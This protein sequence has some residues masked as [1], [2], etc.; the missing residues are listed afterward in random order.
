MK[1]I[2]K[3]V[4][5]ERAIEEWLAFQR[6][7]GGLPLTHKFPWGLSIADTIQ[8]L[9]AIKREGVTRDALDRLFATTNWG[10][11]SCD[12][13][14]EHPEVVIHIGSEPD[15]DARWQTLCANCLGKALAL[16]HGQGAPE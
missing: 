10:A 15:Y 7:P 13:C 12:E 8:R 3:Q 4:A 6:R 14:E 1:R 11:P 2:E 9:E 5:I 16:A